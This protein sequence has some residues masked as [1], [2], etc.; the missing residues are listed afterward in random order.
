MLQ[1]VHTATGGGLHSAQRT[2]CPSVGPGFCPLPR[3]QRAFIGSKTHRTAF[4]V[5]VCLI[6]ASSCHSYS[7]ERIT[8]GDRVYHPH[9]RGKSGSF[10]SFS[11]CSSTWLQSAKCSPC[12]LGPN[13][14]GPDS[15]G[16]D[17]RFGARSGTL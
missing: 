7:H 15:S 11:L 12:D 4:L 8:G 2:L 13:C 1:G 5:D 3:L 17:P 6:E 14:P 9:R 10:P 16:Q